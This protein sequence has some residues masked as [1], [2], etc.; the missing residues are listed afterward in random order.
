MIQRL[1][2]AMEMKKL[3]Y[4]PTCPIVEE[5]LVFK[6]SGNQLGAISGNMT[7]QLWV[8]HLH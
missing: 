5:M 6:R 2:L 3:C 1:I 4:P 7:I 8:W